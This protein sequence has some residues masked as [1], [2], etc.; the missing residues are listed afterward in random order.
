MAILTQEQYMQSIQNIIGDRT[1]DEAITLI[2]NLTDTY[3]DLSERANPNGVNWEQ[4]AHDIEEE[5]KAK[6]KERFFSGS[7]PEPEPQPNEPTKAMSFEDL[8]KEG[9]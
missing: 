4:R 5:W 3:N 1:D 9:E 2:E 7:S 6:Y 8:F